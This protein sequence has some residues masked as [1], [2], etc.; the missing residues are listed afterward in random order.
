MKDIFN[1]YF[2]QSWILT[3]S[4][5]IKKYLEHFNI[6]EFEFPT[7]DVD[8]YYISKDQLTSKNIGD[9]TRKQAQPESS[10]TFENKDNNTSFDITVIKGSR[11]YYEIDGVK[12]DTPENMLENY[13]ENLELRNNPSDIIKINSLKRIKGLVNPDNKLK[14]SIQDGLEGKRRGEPLDEQDRNR[15]RFT[16]IDIDAKPDAP[17]PPRVGRMNFNDL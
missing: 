10:M 2:N 5:S 17:E 12:L 3:G 4:E 8:I 7:N 9:Y 16:H 11:Y 13:E 15:L 14:L 6:H 1:A